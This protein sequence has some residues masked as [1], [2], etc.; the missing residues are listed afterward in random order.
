M[1]EC[2][3]EL[4]IRQAVDLIETEA[5]ES[6]AVHG[7]WRKRLLLPKGIFDRFSAE[8]VRCIFLHELAHIKRRDLEVNW[9]VSVLQALHWFN[10]L[11]WL[12]FAPDASRPG[13]GLRRPRLGAPGKSG[14]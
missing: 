10:P 9:L 13:D 7:L 8:Q 1:D 3:S 12:G 4:G 6:P 14:I 11:V 2:R 5:V